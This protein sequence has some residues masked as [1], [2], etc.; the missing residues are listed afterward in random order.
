MKR[1]EN[2]GYYDGLVF[3]DRS[4]EELEADIKRLAEESDKLIDWSE[5]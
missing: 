4:I 1:N 5:M 3:T 2:L